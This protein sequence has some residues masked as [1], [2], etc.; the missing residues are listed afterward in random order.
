M[1]QNQFAWWYQINEKPPWNLESPDN[2][3]PLTN[4]DWKTLSP[5]WA[6]IYKP[7]D[8]EKQQLKPELSK[9]EPLISRLKPSI[10][11]DSYYALVEYL[12]WLNWSEIDINPLDIGEEDKELIKSFF[13][14]YKKI[15]NKKENLDNMLWD[16]KKI[17]ELK[18]FNLWKDWNFELDFLNKVWESYVSFPSKDWK[19]DH[20]KDLQTAILKT[21]VDISSEVKNIIVDSQTYRTAMKNIDSW[22]IKDQLEW[23]E[24]LY[25]LAYSNEG[26]LWKAQIDWYKKRRLDSLEQKALKIEKEI[27]LSIKSKNTKEQKKLEKMKKE[28][29]QEVSEITW[30]KE[31]KKIWDIFSNTD[32]AKWPKEWNE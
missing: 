31:W 27:Q 15:E 23:I 14:S 32:D 20:S 2:Y 9:Y 22:N 1:T 13:D 6:W 16:I 29:I 30:I 11:P 10:N 19:V 3:R 7:F 4:L 26:I 12:S 24:S 28:I 5:E 21:K 8:P 17:P 25:T 18:D